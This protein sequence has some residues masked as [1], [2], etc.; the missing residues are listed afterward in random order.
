MLRWRGCRYP[1]SGEAMC[2]LLNV[3]LCCILCRMV[4]MCTILQL[5]R[6]FMYS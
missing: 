6:Y 3:V 5:G 4:G 1:H 2:I